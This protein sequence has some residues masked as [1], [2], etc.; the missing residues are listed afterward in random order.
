MKLQKI[1]VEEV[2]QSFLI[3]KTKNNLCHILTMNDISNGGRCCHDMVGVDK[4]YRDNSQ[5]HLNYNCISE[6]YLTLDFG[7]NC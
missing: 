4:V 5:E 1:R 7:V 2:Q 6:E 3:S